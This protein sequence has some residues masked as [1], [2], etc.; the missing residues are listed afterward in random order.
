M[1]VKHPIGKRNQPVEFLSA[2]NNPEAEPCN[3]WEME[4]KQ[5]SESLVILL[6]IISFFLH[7]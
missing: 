6:N 7:T 3:L 4:L 1:E 5:P 2:L